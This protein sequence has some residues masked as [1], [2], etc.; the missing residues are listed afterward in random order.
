MVQKALIMA[1]NAHRNQV[2]KGGAPYILHPVYVALSVQEEDEKIV[3][4][5]HDIVEDTEVTL[6]DLRREGFSERVIGAVD[7]ITHRGEDYFEYIRRVKK[8][9]LATKVKI[10]DLKHNMDTSRLAEVTEK[11]IQRVEK[12]K[13][14]L[15]FLQGE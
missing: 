9:P 13:K 6:E 3:A 5:L 8:N 7:A 12:Y 14:A 1:Y 4:L 2:D 11:A 15:R 10:A